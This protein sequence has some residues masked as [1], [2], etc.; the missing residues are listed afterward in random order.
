MLGP[1]VSGFDVV[2]REGV[3]SW[4]KS[5]VQANVGNASNLELT[6]SNAF[7]PKWRKTE[8]ETKA[9]NTPSALLIDRLLLR[10][11]ARVPETNLVCDSVTDS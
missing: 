9:K 4:G 2:V 1:Q 7:S 11:L 3:Y 5:C 10:I 6:L 8:K